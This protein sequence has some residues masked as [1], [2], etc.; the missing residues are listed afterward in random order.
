MVK[1]KPRNFSICNR[2]V[3][4][5]EA[6]ACCQRTSED[7][8]ARGSCRVYVCRVFSARRR[9]VPYRVL[10]DWL[11][12]RVVSYLLSCRTSRLV[13]VGGLSF[14]SRAVSTDFGGL[15]FETSLILADGLP[16][17]SRV[18]ILRV[19]SSCAIF[20]RVSHRVVPA[21]FAVLLC[22][23]M[24]CHVPIR[25]KSCPFGF[26]QTHVFHVFVSPACSLEEASSRLLGQPSHPARG[27]IG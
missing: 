17:G 4:R 14:G 19:V 13:L 10:R 3:S 2:S 9:V 8:R 21:E 27:G 24:S 1:H 26:D 5:D 16:F 15:S 7:Q 6:L 18:D 11:A 22:R 23:G 12:G 20:C 25:G